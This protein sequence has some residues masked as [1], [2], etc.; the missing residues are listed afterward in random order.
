LPLTTE[1]LTQVVTFA[2]SNFVRL[3]NR[4]SAEELSQLADYLETT[5]TS[6]PSFL[7]SDLASG[8]QAV[9]DLL[10]VAAPAPTA[11]PITTP[12]RVGLPSTAA[13]WQFIYANSIVVAFGVI[14]VAA[15]L[16]AIISA[17]GR[18]PP[19]APSP[20]PPAAKTKKRKRRD[21]YDIF[22]D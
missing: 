4:L 14:L 5:T 21:V 8:K 20:K 11:V 3:V 18:R 16:L 17:V 9:A 7:A 22:P 1:Q 10:T 2:D 12:A 15:A 6:P 19:D 13:I